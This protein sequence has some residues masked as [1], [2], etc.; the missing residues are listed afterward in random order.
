[1][2]RGA[3]SAMSIRRGAV[4]LAACAAMVLIA[5]PGD[6][7]ARAVDAVRA[8]P[9]DECVATRVADGESRAEAMTACLRESGGSVP[10]GGLEVS[11]TEAQQ[12]TTA[13]PD[14]NG[15]EDSDSDGTSP[16]LIVVAG[17]VGLVLGAVGASLLGRRSR[18]PSGAV[19]SGGGAPPSAAPMAP[20]PPASAGAPT[21]RSPGLVASLVD[22]SDRM[23]SQALRAEII[24]TLERA[25]VHAVEI[26]V[27]TP[28]EATTM[29]GVGGAP[30]TDPAWVGRVAATDRC[31]FHDQGRLI[32]LPDVVVYTAG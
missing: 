20:P 31:G 26:P 1:M 32:R 15:N 21:D 4:A 16:V 25:G 28:F 24:A 7:Q 2:R 22:L 30:T 8:V 11:T 18:R 14:T 9:V 13:T 5:A 29:R 27:G 6:V 12:P 17:I 10:G 19:P 23:S 3:D